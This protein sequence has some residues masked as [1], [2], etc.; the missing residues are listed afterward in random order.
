MEWS[1]ALR[2]FNHSA[3]DELAYA[4]HILKLGLSFK[5]RGGTIRPRISQILLLLMTHQ[6][7]SEGVNFLL[8]EQTSPGFLSV[9]A[10]LKLQP[11]FDQT[12]VYRTA[13]E[14]NESICQG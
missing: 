5:T 10:S 2:T 13:A 1:I 4:S 7:A 12:G 8:F 14:Q 6:V 11:I 9:L 3:A